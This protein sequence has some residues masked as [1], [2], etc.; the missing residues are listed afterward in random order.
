MTVRVAPRAVVT[1]S[2]ASPWEACS[3]LNR[4]KV[5]GTLASGSGAGGASLMP[6]YEAHR[7]F[8]LGAKVLHADETPVR[9]LDPG[10]GKT[11]CK[12]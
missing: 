12:R 9:M 5:G 2:T 7:D 3:R 1:A 4:R 8:V 11:A 6:L 10:A